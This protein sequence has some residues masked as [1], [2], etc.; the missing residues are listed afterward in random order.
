[1]FVAMEAVL[2]AAWL[3]VH[4]VLA[5]P[6]VWVL[7]QTLLARSPRAPHAPVD[8]ARRGRVAVLVPAHDESTGVVPTLE[9]VRPQLRAGDRILVVADNCSDDTAEVA[10]AHGA[11]VTERHDTSRRGKGYALDHGVKH[12]AA[13]PPDWVLIC[14][15]DCLLDPG[16]IDQLV[17]S[18]LDSGRPSQA[19]YL[20]AS[21]PGAGLQ[22]RFSEFA[23]R[24]KNQ[25][26]PLGGLRMGAPCQLMGTGML[27]GWDSI[28]GISLAS[29]HLVEDMQM[30]VDLALAG[31]PP[32]FEPRARV[33]SSFPDSAGGAATQRARW[34]HGH[35][36][37]LAQAGPRL[38]MQGLRTGR[39]TM[40]AMGIDLM[41][42]PLALL[43]M[44][45]AVLLVLDVA[46]WFVAGWRGSL[47]FGCMLLAGMTAAVLLAWSRFGQGTITGREM[48]LAL[49]YAL[50]KIPLYIAFLIRRQTEWV[51][52][53]RDSE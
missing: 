44:S 29:G 50:R 31:T 30:G 37:T 33:T 51:R 22:Q 11:L 13:D 28:R 25:V 27:F 1:V 18:I 9:S 46:L 15:A 19:L 5:V 35:L 45:L 49:G 26:R 17:A 12:L 53:K 47:V 24:V 7:L 6:V 38:L 40:V 39:A 2:R 8:P 10:R 23:W 20:M 4:T 52:T 36:A 42:P 48:L 14:D 43:V 41:V 16:A 21:P 32:R 3:A 34:E